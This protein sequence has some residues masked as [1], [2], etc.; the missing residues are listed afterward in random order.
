METNTLI[1]IFG[2]ILTAVGLIIAWIVGTAN[3]NN[4]ERQA[5][6][7]DAKLRLDLFEK[8]YRIYLLLSKIFKSFG[9]HNSIA[10]NWKENLSVARDASTFL[11]DDRI[12]DFIDTVILNVSNIDASDH[13]I[14]D[15]EA[16]GKL[17]SD[18]CRELRKLRNEHA[19]R[20]RDS[21][22]TFNEIFADY[23]CILPPKRKKETF[24]KRLFRNAVKH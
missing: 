15:L 2:T 16:S 11:F 21:Y 12:A 20:M 24:F 7:A 4:G 5:E 23:M 13:G 3:I 18:E 9:A 14:A 8:R 6:T 10:G 17:A 22:D 1:T 19:T